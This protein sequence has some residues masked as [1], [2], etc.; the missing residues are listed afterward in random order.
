[1]KLMV[2]ILVIGSF[3]QKGTKQYKSKRKGNSS[4]KAT[5]NY[6][7]SLSKIQKSK[8]K[9]EK[10]PELK[11]AERRAVEIGCFD[12]EGLDLI[13]KKPNPSNFCLNSSRIEVNDIKRIGS[14]GFGQVFLS[15]V[16]KRQTLHAVKYMNFSH[17]HAKSILNELNFMACFRGSKNVL[18][19]DTCMYIRMDERRTRIAIVMPKLKGNMSDLVLETSEGTWNKSKKD[20]NKTSYDFKIHFLHEL[21]KGVKEIHDKNVIHR[22][23]K[24]ENV[25]I[26]DGGVPYIGDLG[27]AVYD[28]GEGKNRG[29]AGTQLY[30]PPEM[31]KGTFSKKSDIYSLGIMIYSYILNRHP[32][33]FIYAEN[34]N[35]SEKMFAKIAIPKP[36]DKLSN[37][38][39][40]MTAPNPNDRP[41]IKKVVQAI[42]N[43]YHKKNP[44]YT[45]ASNHQFVEL[46]THQKEGLEKKENAVYVKFAQQNNK[47]F[48]RYQDMYDNPNNEFNQAKAR[49]D[50]RRKQI[51]NGHKR[52]VI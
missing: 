8:M 49:N 50:Q 42:K 13:I 52:Y 31:Y 19:M 28:K 39:L 11:E 36:F 24:L 26:S 21:V 44:N 27:L 46:L 38:I 30:M 34:D 43:L 33:A 37:L 6:D 16:G 35:M 41:D 3:H 18:G 22:D 40:D 29:G 9:N 20:S 23:L 4:T 7:N 51:E 10:D 5:Y 48:K 25:L 17:E 45:K 47:D 12:S 1:M 15:K 14:G 32:L 2:V